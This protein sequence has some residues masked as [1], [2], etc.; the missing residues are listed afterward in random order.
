MSGPKQSRT[1]ANRRE[2]IAKKLESVLLTS[3]RFL[4]DNVPRDV[5]V[6][7]AEYLVL[8]DPTSLSTFN[9]ISTATRNAANRKRLN[10]ATSR[11]RNRLVRQSVRIGDRDMLAFSKAIKDGRFL[12]ILFLDLRGNKIGN[13]GMIAFSDAVKEKKMPNLSIL[14][15]ENN[16]FGDIGLNAFV[17][18]ICVKGTLPRLTTLNILRNTNVTTNGMNA[19]V[20]ALSNPDVLPKL[21]TLYVAP[22]MEGSLR[23]KNLMKIVEFSPKPD[24]LP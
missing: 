11:V 9:R 2:A 4:I 6:K 1:E 5:L 19:L 17:E 16:P 10:N 15:L 7:I 24:K 14:T 8:H 23:R 18:A 21:S 13:E 3:T 22:G 12:R 20:K